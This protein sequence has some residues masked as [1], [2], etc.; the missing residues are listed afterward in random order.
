MHGA[1]LECTGEKETVLMA[2]LQEVDAFTVRLTPPK[3]ALVFGSLEI[4][5]VRSGHRRA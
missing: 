3:L 1:L 2:W 4:L 5:V